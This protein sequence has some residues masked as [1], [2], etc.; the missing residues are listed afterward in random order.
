MVHLNPGPVPA[1]HCT[2]RDQFS[3][4]LR[5]I[6]RELVLGKKDEW[7]RVNQGR[8]VGIGKTSKG[9]GEDQEAK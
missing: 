4:G 2:Q 7:N 6:K 3:S 5:E 9:D 8:E 1:L